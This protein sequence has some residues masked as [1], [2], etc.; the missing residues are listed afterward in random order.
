MAPTAADLPGRGIGIAS[1]KHCATDQRAVSWRATTRVLA[2]QNKPPA[3][4]QSLGLPLGYGR[5]DGAR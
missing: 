3:A 2:D 1:Q 4:I 5:A